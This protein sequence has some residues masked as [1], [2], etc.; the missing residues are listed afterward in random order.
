MQFKQAINLALLLLHISGCKAM[1]LQQYNL[2][3]QKKL[4]MI[5]N[6]V[7]QI[8]TQKLDDQYNLDDQKKLNIITNMV[9]QIIAQKSHKEIQELINQDRNH[10]QIKDSNIINSSK[11]SFEQKLTPKNTKNNKKELNALSI[12]ELIKLIN[13]KEITKKY[14]ENTIK[15]LNENQVLDKNIVKIEQLENEIKLLTSEI[16][17]LKEQVIDLRDKKTPHEV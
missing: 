9:G 2:G 12:E 16:Y 11:N 7:N 10:K 15:Q 6:M 17:S 4:N 5:T 14:R 8:I 13:R 1:E 3:D